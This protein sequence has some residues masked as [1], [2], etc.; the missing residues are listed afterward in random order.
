MKK[1]FSFVKWFFNIYNFL[2]IIFV[3]IPNI[4]QT[5]WVIL[6]T[7]IFLVSTIV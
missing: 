4:I 5:I 7:R 3:I 1:V 6:N 2:I